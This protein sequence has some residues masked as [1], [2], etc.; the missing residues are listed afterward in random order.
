MKTNTGKGVNRKQHNKVYSDKEMEQCLLNLAERLGRIPTSQ[1]IA[2][3]IHSPSTTSYYD[4]GPKNLKKWIIKVFGCY[5]K[6]S[7]IKYTDQFLISEI[8]RFYSEFNKVPTYDTMSNAEGYPHGAIYCQ[9]G[10]FSKFLQ[11]AGHI[12]NRIHVYTDEELIYRIKELAK[13]IGKVPSSKD[14]Q[15]ARKLNREYPDAS[16]YFS[17]MSWAKWIEKAGMVPAFRKYTDAELE[18]Y[19]LKAYKQLGRAP[20][21][22]D[23]RE[24]EGFPHSAPYMN[25][26]GWSNWLKRCGIKKTKRYITKDGH[27]TKSRDELIIDD[28]LFDN[29]IVHGYEPKYLGNCRYRADFLVKGIYYEYCGL[30]AKFPGYDEKMQKKFKYAKEKGMEV[31]LIH[32]EDLNNLEKIFIKE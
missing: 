29:G 11:Q 32:R 9:R 19:L 16:V 13:E 26:G 8:Q 25:R 21:V 27:I 17:K 31:A 12:P 30:A 22:E 24:L 5:E 23:M 20:T 18:F 10:G 6:R 28:W 7:R 4:R 1:D 2:T 15:R 3:D 14:L